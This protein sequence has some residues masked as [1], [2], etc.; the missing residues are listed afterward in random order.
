M[1]GLPMGP[2]WI[3]ILIV[4][5]IIFG[6]GKLPNVMRD[7]GKGVKEFRKAQTDEE[8]AAEAAARSNSAQTTSPTLSSNA[9]A[10]A[11]NATT[12]APSNGATN[13]QAARAAEP[14]PR[15]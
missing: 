15:A 9:P 13:G 5:L 14:A 6:A 12:A 10:G 7:M 2:E 11:P 3:V 4:I 8:I 1:F